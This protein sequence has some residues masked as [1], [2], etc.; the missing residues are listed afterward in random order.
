MPSPLMARRCS[1]KPSPGSDCSQ[2]KNLYDRVDGGGEHP[3][4]VDLG[5]Y[6]FRAANAKGTRLWLVKDGSGEVL[7]YDTEKHAIITGSSTELA[8][9]QKLSRELGL[10]GIADGVEPEGSDAFPHPRYIFFTGVVGGMPGGGQVLQTPNASTEGQSTQ[11]Y[12]YDR[13]QAVVQ[14]VSCAS[15]FD[16]EPRESAFF[17]AAGGGRHELDGAGYAA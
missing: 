4:T 10:F 3:E 15:P 13:E 7:G 12:R 6:K 9:E 1:S 5:A 2:P 11:V 8:A 17:T 16:P 14:C